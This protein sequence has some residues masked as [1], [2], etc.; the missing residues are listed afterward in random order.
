MGEQGPP[1]ID[2]QFVSG[3]I[4]LQP[5]GLVIPVKP[6]SSKQKSDPVCRVSQDDLVLEVYL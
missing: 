3:I 5:V 4:R 1:G 6:V 2:G